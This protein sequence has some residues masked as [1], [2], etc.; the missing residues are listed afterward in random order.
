MVEFAW[1]SEQLSDIDQMSGLASATV[2][3]NALQMIWR[4]PQIHFWDIFYQ[5]SDT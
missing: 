2:A 5:N 1:I 3:L 4:N